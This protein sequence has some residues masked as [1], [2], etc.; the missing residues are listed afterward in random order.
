MSRLPRSIT[1][2]PVLLTSAAD[3]AASSMNEAC[4]AMV[5]GLQLT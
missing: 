4:N 5:R 3:A 2:L 1:D